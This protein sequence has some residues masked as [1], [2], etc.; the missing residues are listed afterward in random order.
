[1]GGWAL[2]V[3]AIICRI[4]GSQD[5]FLPL[6]AIICFSTAKILRKLEKNDRGP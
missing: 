5:P 2:L 3:F 4:G 6:S 1:M